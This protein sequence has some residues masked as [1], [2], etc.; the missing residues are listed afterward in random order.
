MEHGNR[1]DRSNPAPGPVPG[2]K[3]SAFLVIDAALA[4]LNLARAES[5]Q[6]LAA[7]PELLLLDLY[8]LP[9]LLLTWVSFGVLV[10]CA[11]Y[12]FSGDLVS[13][14]GSFFVLQLA[15]TV[16]L[17]RRRNRL[18]ERMQFRETSRGLRELQAGLQ[19]RFE[20]ERG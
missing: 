11:V 2:L 8:R 5:R 13:A 9:L 4:L 14:A 15:L 3:E 20:R 16:M 6:W 7:L 17:E 10:A 19:E 1:G 18:R 12:S